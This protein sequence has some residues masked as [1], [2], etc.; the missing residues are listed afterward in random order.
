MM[1]NG[2]CSFTYITKIVY[3][4]Y[5]VYIATTKGYGLLLFGIETSL[6]LFKK[7]WNMVTQHCVI[8]TCALSSQTI[9]CNLM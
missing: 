2:F 5:T 3:I 8:T 7:M 6:G 4:Q 1:T 9:R